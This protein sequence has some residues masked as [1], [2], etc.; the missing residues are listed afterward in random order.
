MRVPLLAFTLALSL[1]Q[2]ALADSEEPAYT[3]VTE[4]ADG[5]E[6]RDY[7]P[8]I[9]A[10]VDTPNSRQRGS[11]GAFSILA[12]YIFGGNRAREQIGMTSPVEQAERASSGERGEQIGMTSPVDVVP[13]PTGSVTRFVMPARYTMDTLPVPLDPRIRIREMPAQRVAAIRFSG[14]ASGE[15]YSEH[16][17][18]LMAA[19]STN[20][21]RPVG[22]AWTAQYN[23]PW[24][25]GF[26]RRNEVLVVVDDAR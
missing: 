2:L 5:I 10:E 22:G 8:M 14:R 1:P 7:A 19:L 15:S 6:V 26:M 24:T 23:P 4:L 3:V 11:D 9:L 12:D 21:M 18:T 13:G 16:Y 25:P 20:Q 17:R